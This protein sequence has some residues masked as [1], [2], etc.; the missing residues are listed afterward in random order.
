M[1][2]SGANT[3]SRPSHVAVSID[4]AYRVSTSSISSRSVSACIASLI[5]ADVSQVTSLGLVEHLGLVGAADSGHADLFSALTGLDVQG[6]QERVLGV[7]QMPDERVDRLAAMSKSKKVV[8]ATFQVAF[9]P[10]FSTEPGKSLGSRLVGTLRDSDALM[11]VIRADDGRD[12]ARERSR[13]EDDLV[14][15]DLDSV[16]QRVAK[17]R[18]AA[19]GDKSLGPEIAALERAEA[20]LGEGTPLYRSDVSE[21]DRAL[22]APAFLLTNK[23]ALV[24]VNIGTDQLEAA[25]SIAAEFGDD[26]L[27]V[28]IELEADPDV[29]AAQGED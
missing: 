12:P 18:R 14:I 4:Q 20:A 25:E 19:K 29:V 3:S 1:N 8:A 16:E 6:A 9:L 15:A 23:P 27:A 22:L 24:V 21:T 7:V 5:P 11:M 10:G 17:Q 28:C 26:A 2:A 13:I